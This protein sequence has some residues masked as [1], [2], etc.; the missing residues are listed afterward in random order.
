MLVYK[1]AQDFNSNAVLV[2]LEID[3]EGLNNLNR[4]IGS[5]NTSFAQYRSKSA[6]VVPITDPDGKSLQI[7]YSISC[8]CLSSF[9]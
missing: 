7:A 6:T 2:V 4:D 3:P 8:P 1:L 5:G 9:Y